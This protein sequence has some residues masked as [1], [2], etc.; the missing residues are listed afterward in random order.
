MS[1]G[2]ETAVDQSRF[3]DQKTGELVTINTPDG[4]DFAFIP[5]PLPPKWEFPTRLWP[6][7]AEAREQL[8]RLDVKGMTITNPSLLLTPL[9]K[10]EAL[11]SSS[12]EGTYATPKELLLYELNPR[13]PGSKDDRANDW[14]E[15]SNYGSALHYG[16]KKL[17][18]ET[19]ASLPL[20]MRLIDDM[21][22]ILLQDVRGNDK[23]AGERRKRQVHLGSDR[24]YVPP[25]PGD[26]LVDCI[27]QFDKYL[28]E[29]DDQYD[30]LVLSY[31]VHYQFEAIHPYLDGNG[32][33]G[34]ALLSLTTF[35]WNRLGLPWLYMSAYFERYKDEYIDKLFN[36][37]ARGDWNAWIEFCLRGTI[38]QSKDALRRCASLDRLRAHFHNQFDGLSPRMHKLIN[39]LFEY[40]VFD[41]SN[42]AKW[43]K[44]SLPTARADIER[45]INAEVVE[46][47]EG[48]RP[49]R[50]YA[51]AIIQV[52]YSDQEEL[53]EVAALAEAAQK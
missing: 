47:L 21:H 36:V 20:S 3:N 35:A 31:L 1:R 12:L 17:I 28:R 25:P 33:V 46:H 42:V 34:R 49:R 10:R 40:P 50:Y 22:R 15:V 32:R 13:E 37:S 53:D 27:N 26:K 2:E 23:N 41:T 7:L 16:F 9:Q 39:Q 43:C 52:T 51:P 30:P 48:E 44:S 45:L 5:D 11:R 18:D 24:R 8:A 29:H 14:R 4:P 38:E 19:Q 6:L